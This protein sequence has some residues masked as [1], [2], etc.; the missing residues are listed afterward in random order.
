MNEF[1]KKVMNSLLPQPQIYKTIA[2][3][4]GVYCADIN[5]DLTPT[6]IEAII[7]AENGG[8]EVLTEFGMSPLKYDFIGTLEELEKYKKEIEAQKTNPLPFF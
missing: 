2:E 3:P 5:D 8:I 6:L 1:E 4:R 7:Q